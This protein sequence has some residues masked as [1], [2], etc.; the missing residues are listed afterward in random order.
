MEMTKSW[1]ILLSHTSH[2][3]PVVGVSISN[4]VISD[5]VIISITVRNE[6]VILISG[7]Y[8]SCME[9]ICDRK[10]TKKFYIDYFTY[11]FL[12]SCGVGNNSINILQMNKLSCRE[13][14]LLSGRDRIWTW[15]W[16]L[17]SEIWLL[18]TIL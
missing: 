11:S 16:I 5:G 18:M 1:K 6:K 4:T 8:L 13:V 9:L 12:E 7:M 10:C 3:K 15:K 17:I 14:R 2:S